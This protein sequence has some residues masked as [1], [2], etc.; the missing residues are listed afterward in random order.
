MGISYSR[1]MDG[2]KKKNVLLDRKILAI[3]A[4]KHPDVFREIVEKVKS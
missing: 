3:L 2:L 1:L 4:E